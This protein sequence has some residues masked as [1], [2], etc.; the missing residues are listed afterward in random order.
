MSDSTTKV[1]LWLVKESAAARCYSRVP[2]A[3]HPDP[4]TDYVWLPTSTIEHTSKLVAADPS[5]HMVTI[6]TWL[7][8]KK[9]L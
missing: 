1:R 2:P 7:A 4:A 5:E 8:E 9:D 3:R 6:P